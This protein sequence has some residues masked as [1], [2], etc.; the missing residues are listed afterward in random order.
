MVDPAGG[1]DWEREVLCGASVTSVKIH[2]AH[3]GVAALAAG[4]DGRFGGFRSAV[5]VGGK[6]GKLLPQMFFAAG[7]ACDIRGIR[8]ATH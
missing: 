2:S 3:A 1:R 8:G 4:A 7:W 6:C 5:G